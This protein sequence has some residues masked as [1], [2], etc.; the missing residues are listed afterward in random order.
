MVL[1]L[2]FKGGIIGLGEESEW[3]TSV[4]RTKFFEINS[5][6]LVVEEDRLHSEAIPQVYSDINE[7]SQ[8]NI[9]AGGEVEAEI[10]YQGHE[11]LFK[12]AMG[13][14]STSEVASFVVSAANKYI[15]FKEDAGSE[16]NATVAESTYIM[17]ADDSVSGSLCEAIKTALESAGSGTYAV[18]F[19]TVTNKITIAVSGGA[20]AVQFLWKTGTHGSDNTDDHIGTLIGFDDTADGSSVASDTGDNAVQPVYAHTFSLAD[21]LPTGLSV[22]IDR[23]S[24]GFLYAGGKI[25]T[26]ALTLEQGGFLMGTFG[27][28]AKDQTTVSVTSATLPTSGLVNFSQGAIIYGGQS[29]DV[30][31]FNFTLNNNLK[32][33][34]R[35]IGSRYIKEPKRSDK[36][37]VSGTFTIEFESLTEYNNFRNFTSAILNLVFTGTEIKAGYSYTMTI[38][39]PITKLTSGNPIISDEGPIMVELPFKA[40]ATDSSSREF[41]LVLQNA[42]A[43]V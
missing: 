29:K 17:G 7:V 12:H 23:D 30:T 9:N 22:E 24:N 36:I 5:D 32:T 35:F 31:T 21:E 8:S 1:G 40:Y 34:R 2:G 11:L 38:N 39:F 10:R 33:D 6:G 37:D 42:L 14:I 16:L 18:S 4:V 26:M 13:S 43:S 15:D 27:I 28:V 41:T 19:S 20:S 3:G 25:N